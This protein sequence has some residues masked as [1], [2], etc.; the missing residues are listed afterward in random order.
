MSGFVYKS[1]G[2]IGKISLKSSPAALRLASGA[3][4]CAAF[5]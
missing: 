3:F 4:Y 2:F 1:N 5:F